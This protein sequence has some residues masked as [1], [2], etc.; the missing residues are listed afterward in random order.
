MPDFDANEDPTRPAG[1]GREEPPEA[2]RLWPHAVRRARYLPY[3]DC[4]ARPEAS[5]RRVAATLFTQRGRAAR[6]VCPYGRRVPL[7]G[8]PLRHR[9]RL[10]TRCHGRAPGSSS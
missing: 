1:A 10:W 2:A 9:R 6:R 7:L 4:F 3:G 8:V 5:T